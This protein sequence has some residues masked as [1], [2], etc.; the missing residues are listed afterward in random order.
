MWIGVVS[1]GDNIAASPRVGKSSSP[2]DRFTHASSS[3]SKS[4]SESGGGLVSV[5]DVE[6]ER[7]GAAVLVGLAPG[8]SSGLPT[9]SSECGE[10]V[11]VR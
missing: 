7:G 6:E 2:L 9:S 5:D 1:S 4:G 8:S 11:A 10:G 3:S